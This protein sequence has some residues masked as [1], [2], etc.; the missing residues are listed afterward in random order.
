MLAS[1]KQIRSLKDR[2]CLRNGVPKPKGR[3][4]LSVVYKTGYGDHAPTGD[5][6]AVEA[7]DIR[8]V[9]ATLAYANSN[10]HLGS[11]IDRPSSRA[12]SIHSLVSGYKSN[13]F[14]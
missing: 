11:G 12:V 13:R 14:N 10:R 4:P 5:Y 8:N 2:L 7:R 3:S 1:A 9:A 6:V